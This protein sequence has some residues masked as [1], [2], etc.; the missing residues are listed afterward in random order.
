[1]FHRPSKIGK[2]KSA[3]AGLAAGLALGL[4]AG[5]FLRSKKGQALQKDVEKQA[6]LL[7]KQILK[8]FSSV[9]GM[10]QAAYNEAIDDVLAAYAKGKGS[11]D[12]EVSEL[13]QE[14]RKRWKTVKAYVD[15]RI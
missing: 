2:V 14:L 8:K 10:T 4:A 6:A 12:K 7:Q 3:G 11:A 1:M 15:K 13:R 9:E 5:L